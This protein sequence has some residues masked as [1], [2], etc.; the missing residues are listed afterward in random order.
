MINNTCI[1]L[2]GSCKHGGT[3][4]QHSGKYL[5]NSIH[6]TSTAEASNALLAYLRH[7]LTSLYGSCVIDCG[8]SIKFIDEVSDYITALHYSTLQPQSYCAL[9]YTPNQEL[10]TMYC[11]ACT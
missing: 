9:V 10:Y 3:I 6:R 7:F 5:Y 2:T 4:C 1:Y 11:D 8:C